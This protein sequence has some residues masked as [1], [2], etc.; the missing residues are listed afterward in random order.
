MHLSDLVNFRNFTR[1]FTFTYFVTSLFSSLLSHFYLLSHFL[2]YFPIFLNSYFITFLPLTWL[3]SLVLHHN[4][5]ILTLLL[6]YSLT[7]SLS[8]YPYLVNFFDFALHHA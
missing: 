4:W 1:Q 7:F 3:I 8:H 2:P 5:H 6:T